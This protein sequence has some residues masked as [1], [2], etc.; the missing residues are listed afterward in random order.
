MTGLLQIQQPL[1]LHLLLVEFP[2][3]L[4]QQC[5]DLTGLALLLLSTVRLCLEHELRLC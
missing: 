3:L 4:R 1:L 5:G 2:F